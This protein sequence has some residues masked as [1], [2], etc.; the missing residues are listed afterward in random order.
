MALQTGGWPRMAWRRDGGSLR[1]KE[2]AQKLRPRRRALLYVFVCPGS[3]GSAAANIEIHPPQCVT[4]LPVLTKTTSRSLS[5][6]FTCPP[7]VL[8]LFW[9]FLLVSPGYDT[10]LCFPLAVSVVTCNHVCSSSSTTSPVLLLSVFFSSA[11]TEQWSCLG[12][13]ILCFLLCFLLSGSLL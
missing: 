8:P 7:L 2:R 10:H 6:V 5:G 9:P 4:D 11:S 13:D 12:S 3:G 1:E